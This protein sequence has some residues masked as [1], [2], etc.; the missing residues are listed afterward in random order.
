[1][2]AISLL[3]PLET[4]HGLSFEKKTNLNTLHPKM[5]GWN[6]PNGSGQEYENLNSLQRQQQRQ[7]TKTTTNTFRSEK[8]TWAFAKKAKKLKSLLCVCV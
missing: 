1:M 2:F 4:E 7:L 5:L 6:W 8:L 3:F